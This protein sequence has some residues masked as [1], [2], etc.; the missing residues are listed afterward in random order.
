MGLCC[1]ISPSLSSRFS[2]LAGRKV[3]GKVVSQ[4]RRDMLIALA[5]DE[6][7]GEGV[8]AD[9]VE[10]GELF[11]GQ[12]DLNCDELFRLFRARHWELLEE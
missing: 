10:L 12:A 2:L 6:L 11:G 5:V 4:R 7:V 9:Q 1:G 3:P 8:E